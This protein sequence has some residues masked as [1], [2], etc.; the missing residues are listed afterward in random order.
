M[1]TMQRSPRSATDIA[2]QQNHTSEA[3]SSNNFEALGC[4]EQLDPKDSQDSEDPREYCYGGYHPVQIGDT[5]NRRYQV[6]S[7]LGWGYFSTVWLCL[8]LRLG[9]RIAVKVLKSGAGFTQA[10]QDELALLRCA[11]GPTSR[12]PSSQRIVQLLDE[13]KLAGV[14]G[15]HMCLVLELLGPDLREWQLCFGNPGLTRPSVKHILTQVLQGLDY[16]HAQCKIIHTDIKPENILLCLEEQFHKVPAGD[17]NPSSL[18][19]RKEANSIEKEQLNPHSLKE[20]TVKIADLGS[21]CWVYKHFCEEI[22]TRQ[23][24]SLEVLLGSEYGP[25][26]DIWSVACMAF[27]LLTGD[28]LFEPKAGESISLEEDHIAQIMELL[29]KIPPDVAFSGKY[30]AEYFSRRGD[31]RRVGPL[32]FWRLYDVLVEKYHFF[33]EDATGFSDFLLRMLDYHP[34][35]RATAAQ[36]LR[37]PWLTS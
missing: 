20:I 31:L 9:R 13:F 25:P 36:C 32:R 12:H 6:V 8:D 5:F 7:K 1:H 35:R 21:S 23:Y 22:Q 4:H 11:S 10:G 26:A 33:L 2:A 18:L 34:E 27:E 24:R 14:N 15:V 19:T 3:K 29:G 16:L 28:S 37:H 17:S 30:S